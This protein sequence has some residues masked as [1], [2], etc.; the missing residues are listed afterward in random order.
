MGQRVIYFSDLTNKILEDSRE[1]KPIIVVRHPTLENGPVK[2][3]V[4]DDEIESIRSS[5]LRVVFLKLPGNNGSLADTVTMEL[6]A[7]NRLTGGRE[8]ADVFRQAEPVEPPHKQ[9]KPVATSTHTKPA[10][11]PAKEGISVWPWL[12][13]IS[14]TLVVLGLLAWT[15]LLSSLGGS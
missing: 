15:G 9:T 11:T 5:A 1:L 14:L 8:I 12:A 6:E 3:E 7:F 10:T 4:S 13:G 2:L